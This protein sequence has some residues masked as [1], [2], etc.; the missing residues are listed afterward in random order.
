MELLEIFKL[1]Q[2]RQKME[3]NLVQ[4]SPVENSRSVRFRELQH[5]FISKPLLQ[6]GSE[7]KHQRFQHLRGEGFILGKK[8][9]FLWLVSK[10]DIPLRK[11]WSC[12]SQKGNIQFILLGNT[13]SHF[14]HS[15]DIISINK[16]DWAMS[17][18]IWS[19]L[20]KV[21]TSYSRAMLD[22]CGSISLHLT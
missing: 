9:S 22:D 1:I 14:R 21:S 6:I 17:I 18:L 19:A 16:T 7:V 5:E 11:L 20:K 12:W 15:L 3:S 8:C 10:W 4:H 13:P 2:S